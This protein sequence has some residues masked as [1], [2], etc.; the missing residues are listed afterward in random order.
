[1][2]LYVLVPLLLL[3]VLVPVFAALAVAWKEL[4]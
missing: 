4:K 1:M 3:V 2:N